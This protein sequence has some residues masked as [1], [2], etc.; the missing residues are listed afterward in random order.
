MKSNLRLVVASRSA[1]SR[2]RSAPRPHPG[3]QPRAHPSRREVRPREG[4]PV[5]DLRGVVDPPVHLPGDR[6]QPFVGPSSVA[7]ERRPAAPP[8]LTEQMEQAFGRQPNTAE[9]AEAP[10]CPR[11]GCSNCCPVAPTRCRCRPR[12]VRRFHHRARRLRRGPPRPR[13]GRRGRLPAASRRGDRHV[14]RARE[15]ERQILWLRYGFGGDEAKSV[16]QVADRIG[17]SR[18]R[19]RQLDIGRWRSCSI[20]RSAACIA[21]CS[22]RADAS[23]CRS[24]GAGPI[25]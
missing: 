13:R 4:L 10:T 18:E 17:L 7:G 14:R 8:E 21:F 6:G 22:R 23:M 5:L 11:T 1:T 19:I 25:V 20:R 24:C 9:L 2:R 12:W 16:A 15:R 3:R